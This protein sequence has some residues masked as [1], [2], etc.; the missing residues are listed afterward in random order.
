MIAYGLQFVERLHQL[1]ALILAVPH[2]GVLEFV[3]A[4]DIGSSSG[5]TE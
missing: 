1:A 3:L 2:L 4:G 5:N